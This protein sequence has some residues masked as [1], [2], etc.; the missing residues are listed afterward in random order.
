[1]TIDVAIIVLVLT[2]FGGLFVL[3]GKYIINTIDTKLSEFKKLADD[4]E[5][6]LTALKEQQIK[7]GSTKDLANNTTILALENDLENQKKEMTNLL[8]T[9]HSMDEKIDRIEKAMI[10]LQNLHSEKDN[11]VSILQAEVADLKNQINSLRKEKHYP[12]NPIK[13]KPKSVSS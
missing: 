7:C 5:T 13:K 9:I 2:A 6:K 3:F 12:L 8:E 11:T 4:H 10:K 1:M